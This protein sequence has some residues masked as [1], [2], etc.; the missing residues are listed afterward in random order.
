MI[1]EFT[2]RSDKKKP[3]DFVDEINMNS[4]ATDN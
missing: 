2:T 4:N 1:N 3:T